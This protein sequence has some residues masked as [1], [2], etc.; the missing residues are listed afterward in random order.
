MSLDLTHDILLAALFDQ[1]FQIRSEL[2]LDISPAALIDN[3]FQIRWDLT[4]DIL[5]TALFAEIF[6]VCW[7]LTLNTTS[8]RT[9]LYMEKILVA[10]EPHLNDT[11]PHPPTPR[12]TRQPRP[13]T[14]HY[15]RTLHTD[16]RR[17]RHHLVFL[18]PH[19]QER[20]RRQTST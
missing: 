13:H 19:L 8:G 17:H 6:Q 15:P 20:R 16:T 3:F 18:Q 5:L 2:T 1:I 14:I 11:H 7:D 12:P 10:S 9:T 4:H